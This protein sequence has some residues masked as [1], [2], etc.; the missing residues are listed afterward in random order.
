MNM[1]YE[2]PENNMYKENKFKNA[3]DLMKLHKNMT[4][5]LNNTPNSISDNL[6][7]WLKKLADVSLKIKNIGNSGDK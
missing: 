7:T 4:Q 5:I 3:E 6:E 1:R 2:I